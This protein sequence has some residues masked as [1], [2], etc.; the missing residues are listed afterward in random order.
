MKYKNKMHSFH[1]VFLGQGTIFVKCIK[2]HYCYAVDPYGYINPE[3]VFPDKVTSLLI[4]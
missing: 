3:I 2:L 1:F 4:F